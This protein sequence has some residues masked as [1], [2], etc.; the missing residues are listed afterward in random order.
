MIIHACPLAFEAFQ[1]ICPE[2]L[3]LED[4][5]AEESMDGREAPFARGATVTMELK[6]EG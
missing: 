4:L 5:G 6:S 3:R 2:R 1:W